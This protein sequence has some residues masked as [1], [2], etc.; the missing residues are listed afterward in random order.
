MNSSRRLCG[1]DLDDN[2]NWVLFFSRRFVWHSSAEIVWTKQKWIKLV[3]QEKTR[4]LTGW[5]KINQWETGFRKFLEKKTRIFFVYTSLLNIFL[6]GRVAKKRSTE[7]FIF[8]F[9]KTYK[10]GTFQTVLNFFVHEFKSKAHKP[11][12][13]LLQFSFKPHFFQNHTKPVSRFHAKS[14]FVRRRRRSFGFERFDDQ[15]RFEI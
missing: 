1:T 8:C 4:I 11:L 15:Q 10:I 12:K 6:L 14:E 9:L 3:Y 13:H 5:K 2:L 7:K